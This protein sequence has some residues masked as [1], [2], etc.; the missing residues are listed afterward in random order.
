MLG[1]N[2]V[3]T[4][5]QIPS[6]STSTDWTTGYGLSTVN[7]LAPTLPYPPHTLTTATI[8]SI[9]PVAVPTPVGEVTKDTHDHVVGHDVMSYCSHIG[10]HDDHLA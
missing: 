5:A 2:V 4:L 8:G 7:P 6:T 1:P 9:P 10:S 3:N